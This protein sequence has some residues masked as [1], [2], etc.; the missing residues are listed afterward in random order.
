M[1]VRVSPTSTEELLDELI[2]P[3]PVRLR[4][5]YLANKAVVATSLS[6]TRHHQRQSKGVL[7]LPSQV[8]GGSGGRVRGAKG[9][10]HIMAAHYGGARRPAGPLP[11]AVQ[12]AQ[13]AAGAAAAGVQTPL[14][15]GLRFDGRLCLA[16]RICTVRK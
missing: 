13:A 14:G 4:N 9:A 2:Q 1:L 3:L 16:M 5:V 10:L 12:P 11:V 7:G 6:P 8:V 15:G